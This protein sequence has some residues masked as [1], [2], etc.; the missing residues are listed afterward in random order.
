MLGLKRDT[1]SLGANKKKK[2]ENIM[3]KSILKWHALDFKCKR[4]RI[5]YFIILPIIGSYY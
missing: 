5:Y 2:R 4:I 1:H 3:K